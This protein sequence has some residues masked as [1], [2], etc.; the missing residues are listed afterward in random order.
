[1]SPTGSAG[2]AG[3]SFC[4]WAAGL[5]DPVVF[6]TA[7]VFGAAAVLGAAPAVFGGPLAM[8]LAG[9]EGIGGRRGSRFR[10]RRESPA[11]SLESRDGRSRRLD[12]RTVKLPVL[13]VIDLA[14]P[15]IDA[16]LSSSCRSGSACPG[17]A[18]SVLRHRDCAYP[19]RPVSFPG[20]GAPHAAIALA[21]RMLATPSATL[22][23]P[24]GSAAR[25]G[26]KTCRQKYSGIYYCTHDV[27]WAV[28]H[29]QT[30]A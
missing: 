22:Q 25:S 7:A 29:G 27:S 14:F 5:T 13:G 2:C 28:Q 19:C 6:G 20:H 1:M 9:L 17:S 26:R 30:Y 11:R 24:V 21:T 8:L 12:R 23:S 16:G 4:P 10:R 15:R 3:A 18:C